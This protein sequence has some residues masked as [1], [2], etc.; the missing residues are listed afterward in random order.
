MKNAKAAAALVVLALC[1]CS[2]PESRI[3]EKK[4]VFAAYP[5]DVQQKIKAGEIAVG[6]TYEQVELALGRPDMRYSSTSGQGS[7][8]TWIYGGGASHGAVGVSVGAGSWG[9]SGVGGGVTIGGSPRAADERER[10]IFRDGRV[11]TFEKRQP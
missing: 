2:S 10:V 3:R 6:F 1:A 11:E 5:Q 8:E 4:D 9:Y 7:T